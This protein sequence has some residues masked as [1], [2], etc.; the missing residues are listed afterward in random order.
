MTDLKKWA[1]ELNWDG[2]DILPLGEFPH[3]E[4]TQAIYS[5]ACVEIQR[6]RIKAGSLTPLSP[7]VKPPQHQEE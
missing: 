1:L 6:L 7:G 5:A 2:L 4:I 3:A